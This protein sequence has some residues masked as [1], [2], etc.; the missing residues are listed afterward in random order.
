MRSK[1]MSRRRVAAVVAGCV[2]LLV[3]RIAQCEEKE[4]RKERASR[5]PV[6]SGIGV[7]LSMVDAGARIGKIV[8][9]SA[10]DRCGRLNEGDVIVAVRNGEKM[11]ALKGKRLGDVVS[12]IRGPVGTTIILEIMPESGK[13]HFLAIVKREAVALPGL[14]DGATYERLIG[15]DTPDVPF[16]TLDQSARVGLS[17]FAGRVIVV[18]FWASWCGTCYAPVDKMQELAR[19]HPEWKDRVVLVTATVD[20]DLKAAGRVIEKRE[21]TETIHLTVAPVDFD[22]LNIVA[23]PAV[24]VISPE[25]KIAAAGDPHSVSIESEV[26]KLLRR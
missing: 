21:W 24:L 11:V 13:L 9:D 7:A 19:S 18:D 10:A 25:G 12:L 1:K 6:L 22:R 4:S 14:L 16:S 8:P 26:L 17:K 15:Q 23:I 5:Y 2:A 3:L 20:T